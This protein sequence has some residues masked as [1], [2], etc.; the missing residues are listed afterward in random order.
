MEYN[1]GGIV[2][3]SAVRRSQVNHVM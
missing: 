3:V 1:P 2:V